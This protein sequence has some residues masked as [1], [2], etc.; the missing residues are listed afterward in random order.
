MIIIIEETAKTVNTMIYIIRI[1]LLTQCALLLV[2]RIEEKQGEGTASARERERDTR[3]IEMK[4]D[5]AN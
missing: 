4:K 3:R 2:D 5:F 1:G